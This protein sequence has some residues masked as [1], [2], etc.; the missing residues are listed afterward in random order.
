MAADKPEEELTQ[1]ERYR[2]NVKIFVDQARK[3]QEAKAKGE[4]TPEGMQSIL[5]GMIQAKLKKT[6]EDVYKNSLSNIKK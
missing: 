4:K 5:K 2:R 6:F 3:V 1:S